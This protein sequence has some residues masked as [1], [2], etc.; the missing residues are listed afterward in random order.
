[1]NLLNYLPYSTIKHLGSVEAKH[2]IPYRVSKF[3]RQLSRKE[4]DRR[5]FLASEFAF[6][7][8]PKSGRTWLRVTIGKIIH[9]YYGLDNQ[10]YLL[11]SAEQMVQAGLA[12]IYIT[13]DGINPWHPER[14]LIS[15][16]KSNYSQHKVIFLARDIRAIVTSYYY[17]IKY[18]YG[19]FDGDISTFIRG[20]WG[21]KTILEFHRAWF[22]NQAIPSDFLLL[23]Y[24]E[25]HLDTKTRIQEILSFMGLENIPEEI[26]NDAIAFG[27]FKNLKALEKK[28]A[29]PAKELKTKEQ[30]NKEL[31]MKARQGQINS[32]VN[33][34]SPED[35]EY[36]DQEFMAYP[37]LRDWLWNV[38]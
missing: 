21:I 28:D 15:Y 36:I 14:T 8:F 3:L 10:D 30:A 32:F 4:L 38:K 20:E 25:I 2:L 7:S 6:V 19:I 27:S 17:H 11:L 26:L 1:M 9:D 34:L 18:R 5:E 31:G 37:D 35:I 22:V 13:H 16:N 12:P 29:Y 23:K 33:D 24:E